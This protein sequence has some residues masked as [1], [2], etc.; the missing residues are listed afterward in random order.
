MKTI[1]KYLFRSDLCKP[2]SFPL[3]KNSKDLDW[4]LSQKYFIFA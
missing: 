1:A 4:K 2:I 3:K